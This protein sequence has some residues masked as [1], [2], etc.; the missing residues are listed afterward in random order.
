M[1]SLPGVITHA[2][3][4][5]A[6][7]S[8]F[9]SSWTQPEGAVGAM[10]HEAQIVDINLVNWTVDVVTKFDQKRY[11]DIQVG[12]PYAHFNRGEGFYVVPDVG[13]KCQ[14]CIPSDGPPPFVLCFIMPMETI[15]G[16]SD[17]APDGTDGSK[18]GVTQESTAASFAG[19]RKR[20]KPGDI[21]ITNRDGSFFRMHR[22]GVV[23]I[24]ASSLAQR[25]F[26]PLQNLVSDISQNYQHLNTGGSINWFVSQGE[27]E[28]NPPTVSRHTYQL[29]A[30]D[31][32]A[33]VRVAIGKVTDVF[34]EPDEET[35]SMLTALGVGTEPVVC[36]VVIA[37]DAIEAK[38]GAYNGDTRKASVLR[39]FFDKDGNTLF[40]TEANIV[41]RAKGKLQARIDGDVSLVSDGALNLEFGGVGRIQVGE[42]LDISST[43]LRLNAGTKPVATVG[44]L[45]QFTVAAPIPITVVV[46]GVPSPGTILTGALMTGIVMTGNPTILG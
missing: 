7:R 8:S 39:Y 21:G 11:L 12:S 25:L 46:A 36:E 42:G 4:G 10:V 22:G 16:A 35:R 17:D 9:R 29:L 37:P 3:R 5:P 14:V 40:R 27:S 44:S 34:T 19:G 24:G 45:V 43:V 31:E 28:T 23:Q 33:T 13:A 15:D 26:I 6:D 30:N 38:S 32:K 2:S 20:G 41:L 1:G 18:G